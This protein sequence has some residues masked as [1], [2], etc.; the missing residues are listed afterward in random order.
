MIYRHALVEGEIRVTTTTTQPSLLQVNQQ[1]RQE[2]ILIYYQENTF[3]WCISAFDATKHI[4]WCASSKERLDTKPSW[5]LSGPRNWNNLLYWLE[6]FYYGE[7]NG[8]S[9]RKRQLQNA[10][11]GK[12]AATTRLFQLVKKMRNRQGLDWTMVKANLEL[13]LAQVGARI[14]WYHR[15]GLERWKR[16][17]VITS[18]ANTHMAMTFALACKEKRGKEGKR[19]RTERSMVFLNFTDMLVSYTGLY[20]CNA[21]YNTIAS[22]HERY[23]PPAKAFFTAS[24]CSITALLLVPPLADLISTLFW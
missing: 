11:T 19:R 3:Y 7:C 16:Y 10:R 21:Q 9:M 15:P 23:K 2:A 6:A 8:P 17:C 12:T 24:I 4:A 18:F 20:R 14:H 1:I 13:D 22:K 5:N